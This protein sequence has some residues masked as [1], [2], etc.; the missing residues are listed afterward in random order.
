MNNTR[1]EILESMPVKKAILKLAIPTVLATIVQLIYNLTDTY[2]VGQMDDENMMAALTVSMPVFLISMAISSLF[3]QGASSYISRKLG[4][5]DYEAV[6]KT[7]AISFYSALIAMTLLSAVL[8]IFMDNILPFLGAKTDEVMHY[9]REYIIPIVMFMP[10]L[11]LS[12]STAGIIRAEGAVKVATLCT[13]I[14]IVINIILD[15]IFILVLGWGVRGAAIATVIGA[16]CGLAGCIFFITKKNSALSLSPKHFVFDAKIFGQILKIGV[17]GSISM[18]ASSAAVIVANLIIAGYGA[19]A[20]AGYGIQMRVFN[21]SFMIVLGISQGYQPFAGFNFG[22]K[23]YGRFWDGY[24]V[25]LLYATI[26]SIVFAIVFLLFNQALIRAFIDE[27]NTIQAG[28]K[29]L[30][31][32]AFGLPLLGLQMVSLTT[33]MSTGFATKSLIISIFRELGFYIPLVL[34][35]NIMGGFEALVFARPLASLFTT[36]LTVVLLI[37]YNKKIK[38]MAQKYVGYA[39]SAADRPVKLYAD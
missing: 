12:G 3:G 25:T 16:V 13:I 34:I 30:M 39:N 17:P 22:A 24:K 38:E 26:V 27:P 14:G 1:I 35:L 7:S 6:K 28:A 32:S 29:I 15:P 37:S 33:F 31:Y 5:K 2:F 10:I 11:I 18:F 9:A 23:N 19:Y 20:L 8:L 36:I 21:M 4:Q